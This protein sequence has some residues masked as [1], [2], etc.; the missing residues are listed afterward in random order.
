ML[1]LVHYVVC[2]HDLQKYDKQLRSTLLSEFQY[3]KAVVTSLFL[4]QVLQLYLWNEIPSTTTTD[5]HGITANM[6]F[7]FHRNDHKWKSGAV[8]FTS[9]KAQEK[10]K[11]NKYLKTLK[12]GL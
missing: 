2:P 4:L 5:L 3:I 6:E 9:E 8:R 10:K 12:Y 11:K 1:I 7:S